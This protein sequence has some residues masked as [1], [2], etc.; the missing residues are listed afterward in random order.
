MFEDLGA[1]S[2][3]DVE[4]AGSLA[5]ALFNNT[6]H[7]NTKQRSFWKVFR[8]FNNNNDTFIYFKHDKRTQVTI[9]GTGYTKYGPTRR[10]ATR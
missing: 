2:P 8:S 10:V 3:V 9:K 6:T 1:V 5:G 7:I 4:A